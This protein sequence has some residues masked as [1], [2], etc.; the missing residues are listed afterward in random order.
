MRRS[1]AHE[2]RR[3]ATDIRTPRVGLEHPT[4][5]LGNKASQTEGGAK[6]GAL[7]SIK[8]LLP[9]LTIEEA[10]DLKATLDT[11]IE[12]YGRDGIAPT[13]DMGSDVSTQQRGCE[14]A[15]AKASGGRSAGRDR[16]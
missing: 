5:T 11:M 1:S 2:P 12:A 10:L 6:N 3:S 9:E 4:G 8:A 15:V 13:R 7:T 16:G 14:Q